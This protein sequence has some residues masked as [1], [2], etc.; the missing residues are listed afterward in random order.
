MN[1]ELIDQF[2]AR[3]YAVV[4]G[5]LSDDECDR[6][7]RAVDRAVATRSAGDP[8]TLEERS[9][10]E[11]A[12][13]QVLNLWE[14][15]P[16]V[17]PLSFHPD[18]ARAAAQFLGVDCVRV[19]HD[20]A[21]YKEAGGL[22]T[23]GHYDQAYWP[24]AGRSSVTAWIP[25]DGSTIAGGAMGYV[26]GSHRDEQSKFPN[27][28]SEDGF[29]LE[30]GPEAGGRG[31]DWVEVPRGSV[32]F[33]HGYTLHTAGPNTTD[34]TRRVH[35][36]IFFADG[37]TRST[38]P[39]SHP[40]VDRAGIEVGAAVASDLTP[41][42]WPRPE[43]DLPEPPAPPDPPTPGWPGWSWERAFARKPQRAED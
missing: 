7:G 14:D 39:P 41:V 4:P 36:V 12:F 5:L 25:F 40:S 22:K 43:A 23:G 9:R 13:R 38:Q 42:A 33:H 6:F 32:A 1:P 20:Q 30:R 3:G 17:R 11:Q 37:C 19:W 26:A 18:L 31:I 24:L 15:F 16:D 10:Y 27:I 34:R 2:N 28:F 29:D 21:L 35:T 8:R